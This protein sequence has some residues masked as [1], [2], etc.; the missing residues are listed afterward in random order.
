MPI[1]SPLFPF[2]APWFW[3]EWVYHVCVRTQTYALDRVPDPI[4][5]GAN[6]GALA[7]EALSL[8]LTAAQLGTDPSTVTAATFAVVYGDGTKSSWA[9]DIV[10]QDAEQITISHPYVDGDLPQVDRVRVM[11]TFAVP[12]GF[13]KSTPIS[14]IVLD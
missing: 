3:N 6:V 11:P 10:S 2:E 12:D 7:P 9:A 5:K 8:T 4:V 13:I 1:L 14:L